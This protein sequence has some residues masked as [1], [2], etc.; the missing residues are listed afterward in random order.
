MNKLYIPAL[1]ATLI[2][3]T[4]SA[5][6]PRTLPAQYLKE[7]AISAPMRGVQPVRSADRD[8]IWS[9]D[10]SVPSAWTF[11][12]SEGATGSWTIGTT[13]PGG[14]PYN[15][16]P[17][18]STTAANGFALYDSNVLNLNNDNAWIATANPIDLSSYPG[19]VLE[20]QQFYRALNG[21]CYVETSTDGTIWTSILIN[22]NVAPNASTS[23]PDFRSINLSGQIGGSAS[24]WIR[25]RYQS[26]TADY[27]W[28][29]DDV[30]LITL[31]D[32]EIL[33]DY[34]YTT[35]IPAE[36]YE[37]G[38]IPSS[39]IPDMMHI[40]ANIV[41]FGG[42]AQTNVVVTASVM[43][44][45]GTE[46]ASTSTTI[47]SMASGDTVL[48][49]EI[50]SVGS[51]PEGTYSVYFSMTSDQ[52]STD[53]DPNNNSNYRYFAITAD[54]YSLDAIDVV[55][56]SIL[57]LTA[58]GTASFGTDNSQNLTFLNYYDITTQET[59]TGVEIYLSSNNTDVGSYFIAAVYD[60][61]DVWA[62]D[63]GN[64]LIESEIHVI[65]QADIDNGIVS[66]AFLDPLPLSPNGYYVGARLY[67][68][69]LNDIYLL[70]DQTVP[71]P[72][73]ATLMWIPTVAQ[74]ESNIK[75]NGNSVAIRLTSNPTVG[76]QE[77][78]NLEGVT[79]YPSPTSGPI[80][81]R[82]ETPGKMTVEVFNVLGS[83]VK[84]ASFNGTATTLDLTGYS[85][86]IYTVRVSD[87]NRYNVQRIT[88]K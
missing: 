41:N 29:I 47:P 37:F 58:L 28:M 27:A 53:T 4:L 40:G 9:S 83:L 61:V 2:A 32:H 17:I 77:T 81:I 10:F 64:P 35:T 30:E 36:G 70:D 13:P 19:A 43:D 72:W 78:S 85:A 15:I 1:T 69:G 67:R 11:G 31:P 60:T 68:E 23:N 42:M 82:M 8:V 59:F 62:N 18:A 74:G 3:G 24:A 46:V 38:R 51:L 16:P 44:G 76:M 48:T 88:L 12:N 25:F 6:S 33:M 66:V 21:D 86:G 7:K 57:S 55:P 39:Q 5:Q 54:L 26:P 52:I 56:D 34:A 20:F 63:V 73:Y 87:G 50:V 71:Q 65:T 22:T 49:D 80:Q 84:T 14:P 75:S 79:M 45:S